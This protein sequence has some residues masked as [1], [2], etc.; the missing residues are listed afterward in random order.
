MVNYRISDASFVMYCSLHDP[1]TLVTHC[2]RTHRHVFFSPPARY[3]AKYPETERVTKELRICTQ[4][5]LAISLLV[6]LKVSENWKN[7]HYIVDLC[8]ML[9]QVKVCI[10]A[11]LDHVPYTE[12][13]SLV[14]SRS[15]LPIACCLCGWPLTKTFK[16]RTTAWQH[17]G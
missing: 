14:V 9:T 11:V 12:C 10:S 7:D 15:N 13:S 6:A 4:Y 8:N 5:R 17:G 3:T 1:A 16:W 2:A